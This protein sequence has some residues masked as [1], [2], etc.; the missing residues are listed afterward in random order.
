MTGE[1]SIR[2]LVKPVGGVAAKLEA[3]RLAG[4]ERVIIPKENWQ[5]MFANIEGM[6]V[7]GVERL[8]EVIALALL[9][10]EKCAQISKPAIASGLLSAFG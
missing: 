7:Y 8:E 10:E 2:G 4:V 9:E 3:A 1:V 6:T 5:T